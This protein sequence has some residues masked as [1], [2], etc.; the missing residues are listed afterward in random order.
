MRREI[1][2]VELAEMLGY[3]QSHIS[4]LEVGVR[5]PNSEFV[6]KLIT[7]L[8]MTTAEGQEVR[9]IAKASDRKLALNPETPEEVYWL[10]EDLRDQVDCLHPV[11]I[12]MIRDALDLKGSLI[13]RQADPI[14]RIKRRRR[15][16]AQM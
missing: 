14:R 12:K 5:V 6:E 15:E 9:R 1:R 11:Q 16:E 10:I 4:A 7:T 2:Q 13:Q 8:G 3:E